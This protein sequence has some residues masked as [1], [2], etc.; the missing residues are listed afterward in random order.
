MGEKTI[1]SVS[2]WILA[3]AVLTAG[4][5]FYV[6]PV[7]VTVI[8]NPRDENMMPFGVIKDTQPLEMC[9]SDTLNLET[10][11][12]V[13]FELMLAT[14][15]RANS[16]GYTLTFYTMN[17]GKKNVISETSFSAADIQDN[18][19]KTFVLPPGKSRLDK[20]CFNLA[21]ADATDENGITIW[22]NSRSEPVIKISAYTNLYNLI[23]RISR[24][25]IFPLGEVTVLGL[26]LT[27]LVS[28][29]YLIWYL[30]ITRLDAESEI[31]QPA[32]HKRTDRS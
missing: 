13:K 12:D 31:S 9:L 25:N 24:K 17:D 11:R 4:I 28:L 10:Y 5:L 16:S 27:Y 19:Y 3:A 22:M 8:D 15:N 26:F 30:L 20:L 32:H 2:L 29:A 7:K 23:S 21:S 14:F 1:K 6:L 18:S